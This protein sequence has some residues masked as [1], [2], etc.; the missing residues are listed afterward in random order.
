MKLLF[1]A[2]T[3]WYLY[4]F[5]LPLARAVRDLGHNVVMV[6]PPGVYTERLRA[7]GFRC[8]S[9]EMNRRSLNPWSEVGVL[10]KLTRIYTQ[11]APDLCH[12]FT[13]KCVIY[14]GLVA[15]TVGI[16]SSV[17]AVAGM[18]YV[19]SNS[20]LHARVL[21]PAVRG[22]LACA[23]GGSRTRVIVQNPDD[24]AELLRSGAI[25]DEHIHVIRG[26]GVNTQRFTPPGLRSRVPDDV[27]RVLLATRLLWDK[28]VGE[29]VEAARI[30]MRQGVRAEFLLAGAPDLGNP[31]A[32]P[33]ETI[34]GW[35]REGVIRVLGHVDD[36]ARLLPGVDI[37]TLPSAYREGVPRILLEAA[38]CG[39]PCVTTDAAGCREIVSHNVNGLLIPPRNPAAL[40]AAL[41]RLI[42][43]ESL[44]IR[45]GQAARAQAIE[46]FDES[47]V[48]TRTLAVYEQVSQGRFRDQREHVLTARR[49]AV[50]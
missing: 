24:R 5:R 25:N 12:H 37:V 49:L 13:V 6:S 15:R 23:L 45:F 29:Y 35:A 14:G 43:D 20:G 36:M 21:R 31:N 9:L 3:D 26:S 38:A 10:R 47:S 8:V 30:L 50:V 17:N 41:A 18:G 39:I 16:P 1:F 11:E 44:R 33:Q 22:A 4:N 40:A 2:N 19:F 27:P 7:A 28:G 32:V 34:N 48:I 42:D 46:H